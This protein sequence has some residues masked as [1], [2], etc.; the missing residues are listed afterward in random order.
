MLTTEQL[1]KALKLE[2]KTF[3]SEEDFVSEFGKM[4]NPIGAPVDEKTKAAITG[5]LSGGSKTAIKRKMKEF[6][7]DFSIDDSKKLEEI[8]EDA[9]S[10]VE[11]N[12]IGE[13]ETLK[14]KSGDGSDEKVKSLSADLDKWKNKYNEEKS[15]REAAISDAQAKFAEYEAKVKNTKKDFILTQTKAQSIKWKAGASELEKR[16]FEMVFNEKYNTDIDDSDNLIVTDKSGKQI[17]NPKV[18]G[19]FL[20]LPEVLEMEGVAQKVWEVNS[21]AKNN[22]PTPTKVVTPVVVAPNQGQP[23]QAAPRITG[24]SVVV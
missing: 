10:A 20:S 18:A 16:G 3:E 22:T 23:Q 17:P 21:H 15:A 13:I 1:L 8:I 24:T 11:T 2:G 5:G 12:R 7:I 6:G 14:L 4:Y 9:L 19:Q